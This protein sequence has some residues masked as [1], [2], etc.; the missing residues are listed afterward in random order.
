M[1]AYSARHVA[2]VQPHETRVPKLDDRRESVIVI[3]NEFDVVQMVAGSLVKE[4]N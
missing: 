1:T 4:A 2:G 3:S